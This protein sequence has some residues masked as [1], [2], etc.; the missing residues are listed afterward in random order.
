MGPVP[1]EVHPAVQRLARLDALDAG[2]DEGRAHGESGE[3]R[4]GEGDEGNEGQGPQDRKDRPHAGS[5][6]RPAR[7]SSHRE[8]ASR[9]VVPAE[10]RAASG[11]WPAD[12]SGWGRERGQGRRRGRATTGA[13]ASVEHRPTA[14]ADHSSQTRGTRYITLRSSGSA[15]ALHPFR[16]VTKVNLGLVGR[17]ALRPRSRIGS[18]VTGRT[19]G[20]ESEENGEWRAGGQF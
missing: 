15:R 4:E 17:A 3:V 12:G 9:A 14:G 1:S 8:T 16:L 19:D 6:R 7:P 20:I 11:A 5:R 13:E 18:D 10:Q 2:H